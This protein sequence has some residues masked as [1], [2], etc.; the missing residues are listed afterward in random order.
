MIPLV[1]T[2]DGNGRIGDGVRQPSFVD[3]IKLVAHTGATLIVPSGAKHVMFSQMSADGEHPS[4]IFVQYASSA[5]T[6]SVYLATSVQASGACVGT[7]LEMLSERTL[8][9]LVGV[10]GLGIISKHAGDLT[11]SWF[12]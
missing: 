8:R 4:A 7:R 9:T 5:L 10:T 2:E 12:G 1:F 3:Y 6:S 11:L